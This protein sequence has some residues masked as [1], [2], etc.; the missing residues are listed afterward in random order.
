M[1]SILMYFK[2]QF[3][4]VAKLNFQQPLLLHFF[5]FFQDSLKNCKFKGTL[6]IWIEIFCNIINVFILTFYKFD[7]PLLNKSINYSK[8]TNPKLLKGIVWAPSKLTIFFLHYSSKSRKIQQN[9]SRIFGNNIWLYYVYQ[10]YLKVF[11]E[12]FLMLLIQILSHLPCTSFFCLW[13]QFDECMFSRL[14]TLDL[15]PYPLDEENATDR[16]KD[17]W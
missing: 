7:V 14:L 6:F 8:H 4:P 13:S 9:I 10:V 1:F 12:V 15:T 11:K 5:F 17:K 16:E 2:I 3:I